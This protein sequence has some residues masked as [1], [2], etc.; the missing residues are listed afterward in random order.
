MLFFSE[1]AITEEKVRTRIVEDLGKPLQVSC[2]DFCIWLGRINEDTWLSGV[3]VDIQK[4]FEPIVHLGR[5][6]CE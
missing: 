6:L 3:S 1:L 5:K 2:F 4:H